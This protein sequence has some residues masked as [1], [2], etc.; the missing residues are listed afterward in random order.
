MNR[1][2]RL[3]CRHGTDLF[4]NLVIAVWART[5]SVLDLTQEV[6]LPPLLCLLGVLTEGSEPHRLT[7]FCTPSFHPGCQCLPV[8]ISPVNGAEAVGWSLAGSRVAVRIESKADHVPAWMAAT[9]L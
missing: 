6:S 9:K 4:Y 8:C 7:M 2:W 5:W 3:Y 1:A